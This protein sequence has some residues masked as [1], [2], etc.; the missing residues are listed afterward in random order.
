MPAAAYTAGMSLRSELRLAFDRAPPPVVDTL[1][2]ELLAFDRASVRS[3]D[4][5]GRLHVDVCNISKATVNPYYGREIPNSEALG[6]EP[7]KIYHLYR[8][9]VELERAAPTFMRL[10]LLDTH[11]AVSADDPK[12]E[13]WVGNLGSDV[14]FEDPYLKASLT[15]I[16]A[17]AIADIL[18]K[19]SAQLSCSYRYRADMAPGVTPGGLAYDGVMRDI[20]GNHVALVKEGRA[21][22]DVF[23][24]DYLPTGLNMKLKFPGIIS[25]VA[26]VLTLD[27]KQRLALD[28][29]FDKK[30]K[31]E[32]T[33]EEAMD[34][35]E[36]AMD[37]REC[38]MDESEKDEV[39]KG[40]RAKAR[41]S[42]K[43]ARDKRAS[44]RK[45]AKDGNWGLGGKDKAAKD[46]D[47][48]DEE[49]KGEDVKAAVDAA[50]KAGGFI[51]SEA[52]TQLANDA[53]AA[54]RATDQAKR[55]VA[56]LV[57]PITVAM[58]SAEA[59]YRFALDQAKVAHKG[60][61]ASA[62][63]SVVSAEIRA[64]KGTPTLASDAVSSEHTIDSIFGAK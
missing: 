43:A 40:D 1:A 46:A 18:K 48:D 10:Q 21:G 54:V 47:K 52:A 4:V 61:H 64:R 36:E 44:D 42:R 28:Q 32:E 9:P 25:A 7:E 29:A 63:A 13:H 39:A 3:T 20:V 17:R 27:D 19:K 57:G 58:D 16:D 26:S 12:K 37:A 6:L 31:D 2:R 51:T 59:V 30:A 23:V 49:K 62:L 35:R 56:P 11:I 8:D 14:R 38:G 41:D 45:A 22:P 5:D 33:V 24:N 53:V 15:V 50:I 34:S 60:I 55:D